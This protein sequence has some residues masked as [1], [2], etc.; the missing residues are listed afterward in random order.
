MI[1]W[2]LLHGSFF[3]CISICWRMVGFVPPWTLLS[4]LILITTFGGGAGGSTPR[5]ICSVYLPR[6]TGEVRSGFEDIVR[7]APFPSS[8]R[9]MSNSGGSST[10]RKLLP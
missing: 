5:K 10:R 8:P 9:R 7:K 2:Q 6:W 1:L 4:A 3:R